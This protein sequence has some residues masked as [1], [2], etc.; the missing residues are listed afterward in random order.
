[1]PA[2]VGNFSGGGEDLGEFDQ[3]VAREVHLGGKAVEMGHGRQEQFL[4]ARVRGVGKGAQGGAGN[5]RGG[6]M[7]SWGDNGRRHKPGG[8]INEQLC[9]EL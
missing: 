4:S 2:R 7:G 5:V 8:A 9:V 1:M 6:S 3:F